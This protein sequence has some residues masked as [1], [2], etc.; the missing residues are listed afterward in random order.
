MGSQVFYG[1]PRQ[2]R[3]EAKETLP[4]K[5]DLILDHLHLRERVKD[6]VV[7]IKMHTGNNIVYSTVH[8]VFVRKIVQAILDGGGKPFIADLTWD[9]TEAER[10]GYSQEAVGCPVYYA[11]GPNEKYFYSHHYPY[12]NIQDWKVAG[13]IE[14]ASFLVDLAHVKGHPS[15]GFG[16]AFKNLALGCMVGETRSA[17]HDTVQYDPYWFPDKCPDEATRLQIMAAC[18]FGALVEDKQNP[19]YV[20]LH[21][22]QCN[23]CGRCLQVAPPGSL[24]IDAVNFN[25]FQ[26]ACAISV[27]IILSTFQPGKAIHISLATHMTPVCDCFGFTSMPI[28]PDA[29]IFGSDDIVAIDQAVL[30]MTARTPL[31]EE[32]IPT[33]FEVHTRIGHPFRWLHGPLKDPYMVTQYAEQLGL[34]SREYELVDVLPVEKIEYAPMEYIPAK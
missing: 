3:L 8:P 11:A 18:P 15:C 33:C 4:A 10:R 19:G 1:S 30:D 34:G 13:M 2:A 9:V 17:M 27:A 26:E 12:K 7:A 29:G 32:N 28:L 5:L 14:D 25:S 23:N 20:H 31:I 6:E 24:K 16:A 21:P 22:E